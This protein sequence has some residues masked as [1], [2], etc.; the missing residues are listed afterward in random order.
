MSGA[1]RV[2]KGEE[3]FGLNEDHS[4][5]M[6]IGEVHRLEDPRK[7]PLR[8]IEVQIGSYVG[9]DETSGLMTSTVGRMKRSL[10]HPWCIRMTRLFKMP[11]SLKK[12][13]L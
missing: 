3:V 9:D 1:A 5:Y 7:I 13:S 4:R 2:T 8:V 11:T 10:S 12:D 6:P